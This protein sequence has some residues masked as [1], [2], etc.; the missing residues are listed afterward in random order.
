MKTVPLLALIFG[1][2]LIAASP[3]QAGCDR[4]GRPDKFGLRDRWEVDNREF[5]G[6]A[7][8]SAACDELLVCYE[9][10]SKV[11]TTCDR[12]F[13]RSIKQECRKTFHLHADAL[14]ACEL[15]A[16]RSLKFVEKENDALYRKGQRLARANEREAQRKQRAVDRKNRADERRKHRAAY[17]RT[18]E[19]E[20]E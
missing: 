13:G 17:Q 15:S 5:L 6:V 19:P 14:A 1:H 3:V 4:E 12:I 16:E 20:A 18:R 7:K 11:K 8:F 9:D 10:G 2:Y